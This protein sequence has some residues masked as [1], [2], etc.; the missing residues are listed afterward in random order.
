MQRAIGLLLHP[1]FDCGFGAESHGFRPGRGLHTA[2]EHMVRLVAD[3]RADTLL[4]LDIKNFFG[5]LRHTDV[6]TAFTE[7]VTDKR[8][9]RLIRRL[10]VVSPVGEKKAVCGVPQGGPL[11][12]LLSNIAFCRAD[13]YFRSLPGVV[14]FSRYADDV[15][16]AVAGGYNAASRTRQAIEIF[17]KEQYN[18]EISASKT[19]IRSAEEGC[20]CLGHDIK[21]MTDGEVLL[22]PSPSRVARL[23]Q[24][25][26]AIR[27]GVGNYNRLSVEKK[28]S[29]A[30]TV[31]S[32]WAGSYRPRELTR[33]IGAEAFEMI[34]GSP[35]KV[36]V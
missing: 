2:L 7:R 30:R 10:L 18:L 25:L 12:P 21:R 29:T 16:V 23:K 22:S 15:V 20:S 28:N 17:L 27:D 9:V 33:E 5:G 35:Y 1:I 31:V 4:E 32:G 26:V 6:L 11:S 24:K 13:D 36:A 3:H 19:F 14:G 34:I 8:L